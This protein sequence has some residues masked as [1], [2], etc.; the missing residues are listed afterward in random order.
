[1]QLVGYNM[2]HPPSARQHGG[3]RDE[4][5][6]RSNMAVKAGH[7]A[8]RAKPP[9]DSRSAAMAE[10]PHVSKLDAKRCLLHRATVVAR[11]ATP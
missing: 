1:M 4:Q 2:R 3:E 5:T 10:L 11:S 7:S 8:A 6:H 9:S